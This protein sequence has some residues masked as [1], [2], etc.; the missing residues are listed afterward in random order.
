MKK[1]TKSNLV[2]SGYPRIAKGNPKER[3]QDRPDV[4]LFR[5]LERSCKSSCKKLQLPSQVLANCKA[6]LTHAKKNGWM[7][8]LYHKNLKV[9]AATLVYESSCR[10][11][12][13]K[14]LRNDVT[15]AVE[16][17]KS[18]MDE[19][20]KL[21][22]ARIVECLGESL[23]SKARYKHHTIKEMQEI[24]RLR[25]GRCLSEKYVNNVTNLKWQC[26][27][28]HVWERTP[29]LILRGS[30]CPYCVNIMSQR[31]NAL[32]LG[33]L[34]A[35]L[36]AAHNYK[37]ALHLLRR[38]IDRKFRFFNS[39]QIQR[40]GPFIRGV[41]LYTYARCSGPEE[42]LNQL[43][44]SI[45]R[46]TGVQGTLCINDGK[47]VRQL[48]YYGPRMHALL[49]RCEHSLHATYVRLLAY[50]RSFKDKHISDEGVEGCV[51][52]YQQVLLLRVM[53]ES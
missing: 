45:L 36:Q 16:L 12:G 3:L 44:D 50:C 30:W 43:R 7:V 41:Q 51:D 18:G 31:T 20:R 32:L 47:Q 38:V 39:I 21:I 22:H 11:Q 52:A 6:L 29:M 34:V 48:S 5:A 1:N 19:F 14:V 8:Q 35:G 40:A 13:L 37:D 10:V 17:S 28:G 49:K 24:A 15:S 2:K 26:K 4:A 23:R 42:L 9:V 25:G 46:L 53:E 33:S 27:E